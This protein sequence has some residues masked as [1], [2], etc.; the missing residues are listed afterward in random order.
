MTPASPDAGAPVLPDGRRVAPSAERNAAPILAVLQA[1]LPPQG[2]LIELAAGTGQHAAA[3]AAALPGID[4]QPTDLNPDNLTSIR[5]WAATVQAPNLRPPRVLDAALPGWAGP[6]AWD[7]VLIVNLLHL[8]PDAAAAAVLDQAARA[9]APGGT[10][11]LYGPFLRDGRA[12]SPG[13]AAFDARLRA[14]GTGAGYKDLAWV[15]DRLAG[16]QLAVEPMPANNL[17]IRARAD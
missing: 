4:W 8:I 15:L 3:F 13:D 6:A 17:M 12:T 16:L 5:A 11:F 14:E 2:R 10:L 7:A 1:H 9:L